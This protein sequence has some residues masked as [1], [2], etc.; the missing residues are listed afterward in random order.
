[1]LLKKPD[2]VSDSIEVC[3]I[4]CSAYQR[5][6]DLRK[7]TY[8]SRPTVAINEHQLDVRVNPTDH[9]VSTQSGIMI[10]FYHWEF[11]LFCR[12]H[13]QQYQGA[14]QQISNPWQMHT[15][16]HSKYFVQ[17]SKNTQAATISWVLVALGEAK[18]IAGKQAL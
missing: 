12:E 18:R 2:S 13:Q 15:P 9:T 8:S 17:E 14:V 3:E 6:A 11:C 16:P 5:K 1:M 7:N 10:N 4:C